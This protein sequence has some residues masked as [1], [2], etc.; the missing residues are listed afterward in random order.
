MTDVRFEKWLELAFRDDEDRD[1]A[2]ARAFGKYSM[3]IVG[4]DSGPVELSS[5]PHSWLSV[6]TDGNHPKAESGF[7]I[8]DAESEVVRES[9]DHIRR[10][11]I[12]LRQAHLHEDLSALASSSGP[13]AAII[14]ISNNVVETIALLRA[15]RTI[16][17]NKQNATDSVLIAV[18]TIPASNNLGQRL[19]RFT[20][21]SLAS[22]LGGADWL[23]LGSYND[24]RERTLRLNVHRILKAE[25]GLGGA[26]DYVYG[27]HV[28]DNLSATI[29]SDFGQLKAP[30]ISHRSGQIPGNPPFRRGPYA[31]MYVGRPWT[32][33]QYAGFSTAAQSNAFFRRNLKAGQKGLSVAFDLAT[34]RG[35]D[36]DH[37]RVSGDVGM[38]GVAID[39]VSD[40]ERLFDGIPLDKM[41]VSMTMNGAAL[42]IMAFF[43]VAA[44][45][46]G[47]A[48]QALRGTLQND[49]LKEFM[50]RNT[51]IYPPGA[52]MRIVR[53]IMSY[54]QQ[55]L[56]KFNPISVS[57]YH[58][59]EAGATP[60]IELAYTIADALE[61]VRAGVESGIPVDDFAPRIS[62]F[63]GIG[64]S[65]ISEIAKLR[66]AREL[67]ATRMQAFEPTN[68]RSFTLR[69]HCQTSGWSLTAQQPYNNVARTAIE[70]IAAVIGQTQSLHTNALDEA[71][72]LP[73][74]DAADI[75]RETQLILQKESGLTTFIDVLGGSVPIETETETMLSEANEL[76]DEVEKAG[77]MTQAILKGIPQRRIEA[78][79]AEKQAALDSGRDILV[80]VNRFT[81]SADRPIETRR[82]DNAAVLEQQLRSLATVKQA[83][84]EGAVKASLEQLQLVAETEDVNL[85]ECAVSAA[86][87]N[88]TVGEISLALENVFGRHV[89]THQIIT[90][91]YGPK[92]DSMQLHEAIQLTDKFA[93]LAGRRP[94]I[95]VAKIGQDGHDRGAK[96]VASSF[97]DMGFDVDVGPLFQTPEEVVKQAIE[98]DVHVIGVSSL[99]GAHRTLVPELLAVLREQGQHEIVVVVGGVI[100]PE[101]IQDLKKLGVAEIFGPGTPVTD[102]AK[103]LMKH[104]MD[105]RQRK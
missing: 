93:E 50:V 81:R 58:M 97:A 82:V 101:D 24:E 7:T 11:T 4:F 2:Y 16:L 73:S 13:L 96:V 91:I 76:I 43:I 47:V 46:Q 37:P 40:M 30:P 32:I 36:S 10:Q 44:E 9:I 89:A 62:F 39:T 67:W 79:A 12:R 105:R 22:V 27:A 14:E 99:A 75:A 25:A 71:I 104:L 26:N 72:A 56:P 102:S 51:Y 95:L 52:S 90:G 3:P 86:R 33:R 66:A 48:R 87:A 42:P 92:T 60:T 28:I 77:G 64:M 53:D 19:I 84:D 59:Q 98:N 80:G 94:R 100:P 34:H 88:A 20:I 54:C 74:D 18:P 83:R 15:A 41:S 23:S 63:F 70:A 85:L 78:A 68:P 38:A 8:V 55:F 1:A 21:Q 49:I 6:D 103:S 57:G 69:T 61:Y 17:E 29:A 5:I 65:F 45:R 35:F 31:T